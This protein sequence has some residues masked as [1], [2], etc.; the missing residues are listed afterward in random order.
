MKAPKIPPRDSVE[1]EEERMDHLLKEMMKETQL[2]IDLYQKEKEIEFE[3][4]QRLSTVPI[5]EDEGTSA[6]PIRY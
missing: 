1:K 6:A 5:P 4:T 2:K 3:R